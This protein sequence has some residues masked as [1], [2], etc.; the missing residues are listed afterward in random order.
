M[1]T[2]SKLQ[3]AAE[4][5]ANICTEEPPRIYLEAGFI[6]GAQWQQ[7]QSKE[8]I[9]ELVKALEEAKENLKQI[10]HIET[11]HL[12]VYVQANIDS[13]EGV[14]QKHRNNEKQG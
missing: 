14:I 8:V 5:Y 9:E 6:A 4:A 1:E 3:E 11:S 10:P 7:E 13:I 12:P 2:P